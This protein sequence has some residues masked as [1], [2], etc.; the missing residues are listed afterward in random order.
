[1]FDSTGDGNNIDLGSLP[2]CNYSE[3][4]CINNKGQIVGRAISETWN[5]Y[6]VLFDSTGEGNNINLN[7][8]IDPSLG[9]PLHLAMSI[10]DNGWIVAWGTDGNHN[11]LSL[12]L[13]PIPLGPAD[14]N[15]DG[16]VRFDDFAIFALSWPSSFGNGNWNPDCDISEPPDG[17]IDEKDLQ[18][19]TESWW[20]HI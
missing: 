10:N 19:F 12:L 2:D 9:W 17:V 15:A 8:L 4:F 20:P 13:T 7:D 14:L 18:I 5:E 1:L 3:A 11:H 16:Y 6:A